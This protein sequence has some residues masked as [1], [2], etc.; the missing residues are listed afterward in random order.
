MFRHG[1]I[2]VR[3]DGDIKAPEDLRGRRVGC[4]GYSVTAAVWCRGLLHHEYGVRTE[5]IDWVESGNPA[6]PFY[7]IDPTDG[8][9]PSKV[10][11]SRGPAERTLEELLL[12]GEIQAL[13]T[14]QVPPRMRAGHRG[15]SRLFTDYRAAE[16]DYY[17][18]TQIYPI[19]HVLAI[20]EE[21]HRKYPWLAANI[22]RAFVAAKRISDSDL[23]FAGA[24]VVSNPWHLAALEEADGILGSN[25]WP[26]GIEPNRPTLE[27]LL[28]YLREQYIIPRALSVEEI[29]APLPADLD[30]STNA[31]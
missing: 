3:T 20:T 25:L 11:V 30:F 18:R 6:D 10:R 1:N 23:W 14:P 16:A 15:I 17:R 27:A 4:K 28:S 2:F 5:E 13:I 8:P 21:L 7:Q 22:A 12:A 29:F 9:Y 31:R 24:P 26:Y 19:M